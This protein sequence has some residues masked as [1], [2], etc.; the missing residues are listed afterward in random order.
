MSPP[1]PLV[2]AGSPPRSLACRH[3]TPTSPSVV[4]FPESPE[5][6]CIQRPLPFS[7]T[8]ASVLGLGAHPNPVGPHLNLISSTHSGVHSPLGEACQPTAGGMGA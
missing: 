6:L 5:R 8:K 3:I 7:L 4:F 1:W 2:A